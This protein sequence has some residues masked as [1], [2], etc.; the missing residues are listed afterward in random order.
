MDKPALFLTLALVAFAAGCESSPDQIRHDTTAATYT[1]V[2]N[3][4]LAAQD[5]NAGIQA[6]VHRVSSPIRGPQGHPVDLN[7]GN[8]LNLM[9]L[10]GVNSDLATRI[11]VNRPYALPNDLLTRNIVSPQEFDRIAPRIIT[12]N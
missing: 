11:M 7:R 4:K 2:K 10:P 1:A 5:V 12:V 3:T 8:K 6:T 9:T